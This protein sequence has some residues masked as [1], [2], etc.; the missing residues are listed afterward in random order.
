MHTL[1]IY[2]NRKLFPKLFFDTFIPLCQ[3]IATLMPKTAFENVLKCFRNKKNAVKF[4]LCLQ[5][6]VTH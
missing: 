3:K 1:S 4:Y 6:G 5:T 2:E